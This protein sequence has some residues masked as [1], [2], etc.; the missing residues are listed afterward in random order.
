MLFS[1]VVC[2]LLHIHCITILKSLLRLV[3]TE[4][5]NIDFPS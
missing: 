1:P 2:I 3:K 4:T 5:I